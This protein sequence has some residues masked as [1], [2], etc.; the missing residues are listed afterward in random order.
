MAPR[1]I[2]NAV[3]ARIRADVD[4]EDFRRWFGE[5]A[6]ASDSG[7]I[8]TVWVPTEAVR[9]HLV[10]HFLYDLEATLVELDRA[11]T[12]IRFIVAGVDDEEDEKDQE[13]G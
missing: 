9:R 5:T 7:D 2:W 13:K 8:V 11:N 12:R 4:A 1:N 3:L 6:Y 10:G